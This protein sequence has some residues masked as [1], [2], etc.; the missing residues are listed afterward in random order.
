[1]TGVNL[2]ARY[3][4]RFRGRVLGPMTEEKTRDLVRRGQITRMHELS[5]DGIEWRP[6]EEYP[7]F[8]PK[9]PTQSISQ[10][11][12]QN[13]AAHSARNDSY[14]LSPAN[15]LQPNATQ[16]NTTITNAAKPIHSEEVR[17]A[18]Q[19][20]VHIDGENQGP[21]EESKAQEWA[22]SGRVQKDSLVW[23]DGMTDW[24][25]ADLVRPQWFQSSTST[26]SSTVAGNDN[27]SMFQLCYELGK[28][29][30]RTI[31]AGIVGLLICFGQMIFLGI[32]LAG[33]I[34][35]PERTWQTVAA[36]GVVTLAGIIMILFGVA[37]C[38]QLM[39]YGFS[40]AS[41]KSGPSRPQAVVAVQRLST[42]WILA[43]VYLALFAFLGVLWLIISLLITQRPTT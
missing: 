6:A 43:S 7:E 37:C 42:F 28:Q 8:Y 35:S 2:E 26:G 21:I 10:G 20:Y 23:K 11:T 36:A 15:N 33:Q 29:R 39:R 40:L 19:W 27:D 41:L 25:P 14:A 22:A 30:G 31:F 1:M 13:P 12:T 32:L 18:P 5:P 9:K 34:S 4:V 38:V 17:E 24:Q 16:P 3:Y